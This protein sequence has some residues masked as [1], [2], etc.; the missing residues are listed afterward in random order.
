MAAR[1]MPD[2]ED[3]DTVSADGKEN[4]IGVALVAME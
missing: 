1:G 4:A 2:M 3:Q